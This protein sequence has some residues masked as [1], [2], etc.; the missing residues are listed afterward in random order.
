LGHSSSSFKVKQ[1]KEGD[2]DDKDDDDDDNHK[3]EEKGE[4]DDKPFFDTI[5]GPMR[6]Q[7]LQ[8]LRGD[9]DDEGVELM[10]GPPSIEDGDRGGGNFGGD[11]DD[12]DNEEGD[13]EG[14]DM[15]MGEG[16]EVLFLD[17]EGGDEERGDIEEEEEEGKR[18]S[19]FVEVVDEDEST[20]TSFSGPTTKKPRIDY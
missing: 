1:L 16:E 5:A 15:H 13:E 8:I 10:K 4:A 20:L 19:T 3:D 6:N 7:I 2:R 12:E 17:G 14:E 11:D 9:K 18:S